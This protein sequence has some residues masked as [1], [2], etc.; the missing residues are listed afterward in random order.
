[1]E[2]KG[3]AGNQKSWAAFLR[4]QGPQGSQALFTALLSLLPCHSEEVA[5]TGEG[6]LYENK[7]G[8]Q[9]AILK[10]LTQNSTMFYS[11]GL[12]PRKCPQDCTVK[13]KDT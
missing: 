6:T 10:R 1:M 11:V 13:I 2:E 5:K 8:I 7:K 9:R 4:K 3:K 12:T